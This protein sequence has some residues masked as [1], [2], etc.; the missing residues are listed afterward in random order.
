VKNKY[1]RTELTI[2]TS[3]ELEHT[4]DPRVAQRIAKDHLDE[5][6]NY[7]S[8]L[9]QCG[10]LHNGYVPNFRLDKWGRSGD[11]RW[12]HG[13][14]RAYG[15]KILEDGFV[16]PREADDY[17][18]YT[19]GE[20]DE[21]LPIPGRTYVSSSPGVALKYAIDGMLFEPG[22]SDKF[23]YVFEVALPSSVDVLLDED[24]IAQDRSVFN[25]IGEYFYSRGE[26]D[27]FEGSDP[28]VVAKKFTQR[29]SDG[30][31]VN[32]AERIHGNNGY[33]NLAVDGP[34][35]VVGAWK[36]VKSEYDHRIGVE[37]AESRFLKYAKE[38]KLDMRKNGVF[39]YDGGG[40]RAIYYRCTDG[41]RWVDLGNNES[42]EQFARKKGKELS[43]LIEAGA[44][45]QWDG[46]FHMARL[47][48]RAKEAISDR[49]ASKMP[50]GIT[51]VDLYTSS[52]E[53]Y[54][55]DRYYGR[56]SVDQVLVGDFEVVPPS[57]SRNSS[58]SYYVWVVDEDGN[59][60]ES[61]GVS[62]P[63]ERANAKD[64]ARIAASKGR[65]SRVVTRGSD[66]LSKSFEIVEIY[67]AGKR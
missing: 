32:L 56:L 40:V 3:V 18:K 12:Y 33:I 24:L 34:L 55:A 54:G 27:G 60:I 52:S 8:H 43:E 11:L 50:K 28:T 21:L 36:Y 59:Y 66:P 1:D 51:D 49:L 16:R 44:I 39:S 23:C 5:D 65:N 4:D 38:V 22:G 46:V 17:S 26:T 57:Y 47:S 62:G 35:Q 48:K 19:K 2:G 67:Q 6:P 14:G 53:Q 45:T 9:S 10:M 13:T 41:Y 61:E 30:L 7:Y 37:G 29:I 20:E 63:H 58:K 42:H 31:A 15:E 25:E 64:Y